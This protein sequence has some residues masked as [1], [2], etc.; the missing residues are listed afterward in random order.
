MRWV[1]V[2]AGLLALAASCA[3]SLTASGGLSS[4]SAP[5]LIAMAVVLAVGAAAIGHALA[6]RHVGIA[7]VIGLGML[8]GEAGA[9]LQTAQR[10]TAAREAMRGPLA[11]LALKRQA[12]VDELTKAEAAKPG[13]SNRSRLD[14]AERAKAEAEKAVRDK[15]ADKGCRENCR[16]LLQ[17]AVDSAAREVE[18]ARSEIADHDAKQGAAITTRV[19]AARAALAALPAPQSATPLADNTGLPEWL[20]DTI[21]ALALS[22][23]INLPASALIALGVKMGARREPQTVDTTAVDLAYVKPADSLGRSVLPAPKAP[24]REAAIEAERFGVAML[25]PAKGAR[26]SPG[27]L[28]AAYIGW[29]DANGAEPLP[30]SEIAPALGALFRKAGIAIGADGVAVG[31]KINTQLALCGREPTGA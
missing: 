7:I 10:V 31:V 6:G 16:L 26:L 1:Y 3:M 15:S 22:L 4:Q 14:A 19:E 2:A 18:A 17:A 28:R 13:P 24:M 9:M 11:A 25:R 23:A 8:A 21:E 27:E 12:A 30:M 29:C 5:G 20:L